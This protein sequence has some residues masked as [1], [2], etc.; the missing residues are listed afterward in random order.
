MKEWTNYDIAGDLVE[1]LEQFYS[2]ECNGKMRLPKEL[3]KYAGL[4]SVALSEAKELRDNLKQ[5]I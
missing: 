2:E 3:E 4:I 1:C 5:N